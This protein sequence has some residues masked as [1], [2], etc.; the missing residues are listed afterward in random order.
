MTKFPSLKDKRIGYG[1]SGVPQ[2]E[3]SIEDIRECLIDKT[4]HDR[5]KIEELQFIRRNDD[6]IYTEMKKLVD[7]ADMQILLKKCQ[8]KRAMRK[9]HQANQDF[10]NKLKNIFRGLRG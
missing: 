6:K 3:V 4:T 1:H 9:Y 7:K 10:N 8:V 2:L 5:E